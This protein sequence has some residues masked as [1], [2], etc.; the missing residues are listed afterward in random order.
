MT[1]WSLHEAECRTCGHVTRDAET[2]D[3]GE[4]PR[5]VAAG[6]VRAFEAWMSDLVCVI[7]ERPKGELTYTQRDRLAAQMERLK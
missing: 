7:G 3:D 1:P 6:Q 4:C 5:C 2:F